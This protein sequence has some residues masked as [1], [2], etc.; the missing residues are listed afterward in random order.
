VIELHD[1]GAMRAWSRRIRGDGA[2]VGF[3]PTMGYLHE[4]H[5]RL[6]DRAGANSDAV[7]VSIFVNPAQFGP[8]EDLDR[9]PRDLPRDRELAAARGVACLFTPGTETMYPEPPAVGVEPGPLA[10]H[11]CGPLRPGHFAGVLLVVLKLLHI[12]EPDVAVFGRKDAQQAWIIRRMVEDLH[13]PVTIDI[14]PTVRE[15][16]GLAM[17]SRNVYLSPAERRAATVLPQ[18]LDAGH[19]AYRAGTRAA[20]DVIAAVRGV[21]AA[22]AGVA[23]EYVEAVAPGT[24]A[25]VE[26]VAPETLLA[27]AAR[28]GAT[29]LI[30]NIVLGEGLAGD[31]TAAV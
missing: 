14:A 25:P 31:D 21:L 20:S 17:S 22:E 19:R 1:V 11:L 13:L 26:R 15:P 27:V 29:R 5:L 2:R 4:G 7:A 18:A 16:D 10:D 30:D 24:L 9:Y 12:V 3:V 6:V 28:V 23:V 8:T